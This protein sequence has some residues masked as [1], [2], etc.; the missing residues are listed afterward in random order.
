[1]NEEATGAAEVPR[2][3]RKWGMLCHLIALSGLIGNGIGFI[4]GPLIVWLVK[5]DDH[6][7]ID[8]QGKE[9]LNFQITMFIVLFIS[10]I[11]CLFLIGF[12]FLLV[13]AVFMAVFPVIGALS[14]SEGKHYRY[15]FSIRF[16]K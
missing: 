6:P 8:E 15:P 2:G 9:S 10:A 11:L 1:M 4:L 3:A 13:V 5:R 16:F 12:V 7:F 14:A